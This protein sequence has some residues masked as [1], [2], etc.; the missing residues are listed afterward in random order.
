MAFMEQ[1]PNKSSLTGWL[2]ILGPC[3]SR[4]LKSVL[5]CALLRRAHAANLQWELVINV[6][7]YIARNSSEQLARHPR[8]AT[9][10]VPRPLQR[11]F[12]RHVAESQDFRHCTDDDVVVGPL[13]ERG[14][15]GR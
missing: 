7:R 13:Q 8:E 9:G 6:M 11:C 1:K 5:N 15:C 4:E 3:N 10:A 12:D 14:G 2:S